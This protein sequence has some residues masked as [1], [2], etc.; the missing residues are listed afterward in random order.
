[1]HVLKPE[2]TPCT[3]PKNQRAQTQVFFERPDERDGF[4]D[5]TCYLPDYAWE[6]VSGFSDADME[7]NG[8]L[9]AKNA[10]VVAK[11]YARR[12]YLYDPSWM[13][14]SEQERFQRLTGGAASETELAVSLFWLSMLLRNH[15]GSQVVILIDEYDTPVNDAH[16]HGF[17]HKVLD[18]LPLLA[19]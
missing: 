4:H 2:K 8:R 5:A 19:L 11:E 14:P 6:S 12:R 15:H 18:F 1:M 9:L 7:R 13:F 3:F 10:N 17:R 16:L